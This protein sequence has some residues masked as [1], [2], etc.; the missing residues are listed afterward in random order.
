MAKVAQ[1]L[2]SAKGKKV[3]ILAHRW[4][5]NVREMLVKRDRKSQSLRYRCTTQ[6]R[7]FAIEDKALKKS[8]KHGQ[9]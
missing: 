4:K 7:G 9:N 2:S 8:L 6:H 5:R 1:D 3:I